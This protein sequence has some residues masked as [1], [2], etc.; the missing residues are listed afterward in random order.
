MGGGRGMRM[1][2]R[3]NLSADQQ[4]RLQPLFEEQ[5]AQRQQFRSQMEAILTPEQRAQMQSGG[6]GRRGGGMGGFRQLNLSEDQKARMQALRESMRPQMR[7]S[8][9]KM[10]SQMQSVLTPEQMQQLNEMRQQRG[11]GR[12]G[13]AGRGDRRGNGGSPNGS[14][15][16][17]NP[18]NGPDMDDE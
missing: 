14:G 12:G 4:A 10:Q 11:G 7:A 3:L 2:Q 8:R 13:R 18:P 6:G 15:P 1:M 16:N 5:Q 9:Q 17:G